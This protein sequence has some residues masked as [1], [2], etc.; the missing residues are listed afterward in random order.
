MLVDRHLHDAGRGADHVRR[1]RRDG[2]AR[3]RRAVLADGRQRAGAADRDRADHAADGP[4]VPAHAGRGSTALNRVLRE[5]ITGIR[6][7]R[8]FVREPQERERFGVANDELTDDRAAGRPAAGADLPDRDA[9]AQR[10]RASRCCGS[11]PSAVDDG[12]DADRRADR[13]PDLPDADPDVRDDGDL[14]ADDGAARG[15]L[16]RAHRRGARHRVV[17]GGRGE[18][19]HRPRRCAATSSCAACVHL[20]GRRGAGAA[21]RQL[22]APSPGRRPPSS[23]APAP[24]RPRCCR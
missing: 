8:A 4:A 12:D 5:Q 11:A 20:P 22:H 13:V 16:R 15:R 21:R 23:A 3:G 6:V 24:A 17:R 2:A 14:H 10:C 19:R 1:R 18:R 9:G 7:V